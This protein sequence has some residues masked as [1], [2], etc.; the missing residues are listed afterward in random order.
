M[1]KLII[2][3]LKIYRLLYLGIDICTIQY[4]NKVYGT[5]FNIKYYNKYKII[6]KLYCIHGNVNPVDLKVN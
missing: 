3:S 1:I 5:I 6:L 4:T 2:D